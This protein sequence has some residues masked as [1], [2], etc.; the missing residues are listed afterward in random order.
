MDLKPDNVLIGSPD[1]STD[2]ARK[3]YLI[4]FGISEKFKLE[5]GVHRRKIKEPHFRGNLIFSSINS[6]FG[7][8][9]SRRDDLQ[10]LF[11]MLIY[12]MTGKNLWKKVDP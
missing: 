11:Y 7:Y 2:K 4:D 6:M 8:T 9:P 5:N 12:F 3:L 10:S 1:M